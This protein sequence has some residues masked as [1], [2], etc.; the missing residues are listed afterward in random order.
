MLLKKK[1]KRY[2][3]DKYLSKQDRIE[4]LMKWTGYWRRNPH[5]FAE[6]FLG[7]NLFTFQKILL[8]LMQKYNIFMYIASR[9]I[10]KSFIVAVYCVMRCILYPGT[11]VIVASGTKNQAKLIIS[12]KIVDLYKNHASIRE[13]IG[14]ERNIKTGANNASVLF[15][16]GSKIEA[17]TSSDNSRGFRGNILILDEFRLI[18]RSVIQEVLTPMLNV[19]RKPPFTFKEEYKDYPQEENKTIYISSAWYKSHWSWEDFKLFTKS[20]VQGKKY[21]TIATAYPLAI[22]HKLLNREQAENDR[23]EYDKNRWDMEYEAVFV[24]ENDNSYFK[25]S[26]INDTRTVTKALIPPKNE[27]YIANKQKSRPQNLSN[28]PRVNMDTEIRIVSLDV[29]LMGRY[30]YYCPVSSKD[31]NDNRGKSV[32]AK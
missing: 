32:K 17:V 31:D 12:E 5:H 16:N 1:S 28:I 3:S 7:L 6:D 14:N 2:M 8:F 10:G 13:E 19:V 11:K 27:D 22:Y 26:E 29:A 21:F 15:K 4:N 23:I 9:G 30:F 24:G 25:L 18:E 20:M